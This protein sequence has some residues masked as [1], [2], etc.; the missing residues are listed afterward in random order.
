[1]RAELLRERYE[2]LEVVGRGGEGEVI[3]AIDHLH[4]RQVALKVRAVTDDA[5]R[6]ALL[7]EARLLLS[8]RPHPGL[9]LAREDFF[10]D[11]RYVIAMDWI[12]GT[13]LEALLALEG[14]PGLHP[15]LA[16]GYLRQAAEALEHLHAH[17]PPIVH[18]DVKPANLILTSAGRVV[19]VDFG[20]SSL[21][22]DDVRR[23]GT[24]GFVAPEV[25]AGARPTRAA[26][27][28][29]LAATAVA[30]LAG[31]APARGAPGWGAV[32]PERAPALER[33]VRPNLATDPSRRDASARAFAARL[34]RWWGAALPS[35]TVTLVVAD[36]A[37]IP[38]RAAEDAVAEVAGAHRGSCVAPVDDGSLTAAFAS[39]ADAV[40]AA[41]ELAVRHDARVSAV[42][43]ELTPRAGRYGG[44][45]AAA[46]VGLLELA[47][48]RQV[49]VDDRTAEAIEDRLPP[50]LGLASLRAA[51][52]AWAWALVA[53][54]LSAPSRAEACPYRGL[55]TFE[56]DDGDLFFGR[57]EIVA[58]MLERLL[59][60]RFLAVVGASG[61]GKSSLVRAGLVPAFRRARDGSV[62][63]ITPGSDPPS[64]LRR[65]LSGGAPALLV[66]D[67]LEELF[68][69][70]PDEPTRARFVAGLMDLREA[71][72]TAVLV[73]LRADFYGRCASEPRLAAAIAERQHLLGPMGID[74]LRQAVEGPARVAG[75]RLQP[76]L[77]DAMLADVDGE[78]GALPLLS[79]ALYES[80]SRR[81]GQLL[82]L[83]GYRAAG[84][85]RGAIAH[86][87]EEV[88][89]GCGE[90]ERA[91]MRRLLLQLTELGEATEDTRRGVPLA[92]LAPQGEDAREAT[93][94]LERLAGARLLVVGDDTAEIAHEALI[95][96]WPR[97][98]GWLAE[99]RD[100]L[101][102]LRQLA[103]AA[104]S[105][106]ENGRDDADLYRGPRLEAAVDVAGEQRQLAPVDREFLQA[107]RDAQERELRTAQ[108]RARRLRALLAVVA[109][110]L[111]AAVV[112]GAA[113]LVQRGNARHTATVAQAG[114]LAAQSREVAA[115]QPDLG[116][117]LALEA[118]RLDDSVDSR[119]A[120]LGALE[121]ASRVR[122]WLQGFDSPVN[123]AAFS[124][125][126]TL[127]A[128]VTLNEAALWDTRTWRRAGPPLGSKQGGWN[129]VDFSPDGRTLALA[130]GQGRVELWDV[131]A[132]TERRQ[133]LDPAAAASPEPALAVV[134]FSPDGSVVAAGGLEANHVTLWDAATGRVLGRPITTNP[135]GTG[136]AQSISFS[137]DSKRIAVPG[138]GGT[139]GIW[140]VATGRRVGR[141]LVVGL[142]EVGA[143][144]FADGGRTLIASDDSGAVSTLDVA[145]GRLVGSPLSVGNQV[146]DSL[147][148]SPDGRLLAAASFDG[149]VFVW[150]R[151]SGTLFGTALRADASPVNDVVFSPDGRTLVTAHLR[152]TVAWDLSG[153]HVLG[154]PLGRAGDPV[155][156]VAF[157]SDGRWL[158]AGQFDGDTVVYDARRRQAARRIEGGPVVSTVAVDP[159]ATLVA[160][161][162]VDG[163]VRLFDRA[164]GAA[165]GSPLDVGSGAVWQV[166]FSP[167]GG[168]LAVAF[169]PNGTGDAFYTQ[170]RQGEI[171]LW[172]VASRRRAGRA[173]RPGGGSV[174]SV[175]FSSDGALLATGSYAGRLDLWDVATRRHQGTPLRVADDGVLSVAFDPSGRLVAGGGA[176]GPVRVWRAGDGSPAFPPLSGHTG[177]VTGTAFDP[178]G[179]LLATT[180]LFGDTRLWD[181][182]TGLPFGDELVSPR[183]ES[184]EPTVDLPALGLRNAFSPDGRLLAAAGVDAQAMVWE[185]D[186]AVWRLRACAIAGR[187][188][189]RDE[190]TLYLPAAKPYRPTC[191]EW[192]AG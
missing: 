161:G 150:D 184:L 59:E 107:S 147:D 139:V 105:W 74:E 69:L 155:T 124:P 2:P 108:R 175:A 134:R 187:N 106:A 112:A 16:V 54:G 153:G 177:Y 180:S 31:A 52:P 5:S 11:G 22:A 39:A 49:V 158:V 44:T 85:V 90:A 101:R 131:A 47:G 160:V 41:R 35:G 110:A 165:V 149:R 127:L 144:V 34:E 17:E 32:E 114:R 157:S 128:T 167:D 121:H 10:V 173:I 185:V 111:V 84:G 100:Q 65:S 170:Q 43:G 81:E 73:T 42:T 57:E 122:A 50:E 129:G 63:V 102:A 191:P 154:A 113:A 6:T 109:A 67:Q 125:D 135:P 60:S 20:L 96:E 71:G 146:A 192:P 151:P 92:E 12:E 62:V 76:G 117:L 159:D 45:A 33:I 19:L 25:A 14:R 188:L 24:A 176:T 82:T 4:A 83:A 93:A 29:S 132:R 72:G 174:F 66:V 38:A 104:R 181:P 186:P 163:V 172:D 145:S 166:A 190:W 21:P 162:T 70:C 15:A 123:A 115:Q 189:S 119:G 118:D 7:S 58:S 138:A 78:P 137:P 55:M 182:A 18:G 103:T 143:A 3:R 40:A 126:G 89:L 164:T 152:S 86:S 116:L 8:L 56:A 80:W 133:L 30:L 97:L 95:R 68:T 148:L 36:L 94:V 140:E 64:A 168:L 79:H 130:G 46:A 156:D 99:D 27:V 48:P 37:A 88:F 13:D 120:L 178:A 1:M 98:R 75:L 51:G 136:G 28:Y 91:S 141:P 183:P 171:Q 9:P 53:P 77:V 61:S 179:R 23:A 142:A 169:D 87:A 26:D